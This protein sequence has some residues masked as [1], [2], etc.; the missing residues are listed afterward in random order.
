MGNLNFWNFDFATNAASEPLS[1]DLNHDEEAQ[2]TSY[3]PPPPGFT[4]SD[5]SMTDH[6]NLNAMGTDTESSSDSEG[7]AGQFQSEP[8]SEH[9][10]D[11]STEYMANSRVSADDQRDEIPRSDSFQEPSRNE[12]VDDNQSETVYRNQNDQ[13]QSV[14]INQNEEKHNPPPQA[15]PPQVQPQHVPPPQEPL[16]T[17]TERKQSQEA[18][19]RERTARR[20]E[21]LRNDKL[22]EQNEDEKRHQIRERVHPLIVRRAHSVR[23]NAVSLITL[24]YPK[25]RLKQSA[26][27]KDVLK[28]FKRALANFHPDRTVHKSLEEQVEAE[29]IFKLLSA[30]KEQFQQ[31][32]RGRDQ[33]QRPRQGP[34]RSYHQSRARTRHGWF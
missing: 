28:A 12:M 3:P 10:E 29:E 23:N 4:S 17:A 5:E 24:F 18:M 32:Q 22:K 20:L 30:E 16:V 25:S 11:R 14:N 34:H 1:N 15:P 21:E 13:N 33:G 31:R 8:N 26:S 2:R 9:K 6:S 7:A 19:V 27:S